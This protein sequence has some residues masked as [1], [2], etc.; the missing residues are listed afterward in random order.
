MTSGYH[1][2]SRREFTESFGVGRFT[3][4]EITLTLAMRKPKKSVWLKREES[5]YDDDSHEKD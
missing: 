3:L 4:M 2:A 1:I 5:D